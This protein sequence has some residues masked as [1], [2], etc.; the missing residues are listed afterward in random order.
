MYLTQGSLTSACTVP[1]GQNQSNVLQM[2]PGSPGKPG[3]RVLDN[4]ISRALGSGSV[5]VP[6][7]QG[8]Q[9]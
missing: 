5:S 3:Q 4:V 2:Q 1:L 8:C 9:G 6:A 7:H